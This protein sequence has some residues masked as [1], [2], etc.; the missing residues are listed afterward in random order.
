MKFLPVFTAIV[1]EITLAILPVSVSAYKESDSNLLN[2][3]KWESVNCTPMILDELDKNSEC[4]ELSLTFTV[5]DISQCSYYIFT[6]G[7]LSDYH[8]EKFNDFV[9]KNQRAVRIQIS[10]N[11]Y[12]VTGGSALESFTP[13]DVDS[14]SGFNIQNVFNTEP[15]YN[16]VYDNVGKTFF[17][18]GESGNV[19]IMSIE[20]GYIVS[21]ITD[22]NDF[23]QYVVFSEKNYNHKGSL[24]YYSNEYNNSEFTKVTEEFDRLYMQGKGQFVFDFDFIK[25][26]LSAA[27][28]KLPDDYVYIPHDL[29]SECKNM[30]KSINGVGFYFDKQGICRGRYTGWVKSS[31]GKRYFRKGKYVTGNKV[32][33]D[34]EY[35]FDKNG[36]L[37]TQ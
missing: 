2:F 30:L 21:V 29:E 12:T 26:A 16:S 14:F 20:F 6:K 36:Y 13:F 1:L 28:G 17:Q 9:H 15:N 35:S 37:I 5:E 10:K 22:E 3:E 27:A 19:Y 25:D 7:T 23:P 24:S 32:V 8:G 31:K 34:I 11:G 4:R 33:N 18:Y